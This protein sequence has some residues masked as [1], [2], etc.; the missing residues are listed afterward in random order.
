[1]MLDGISSIIFGVVAFAWPGATALAIIWL[2][3]IHAIK[4]G[5][6]EIVLSVKVKGMGYSMQPQPST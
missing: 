5:L 1:M 3:G 4:F 6:A 2:I